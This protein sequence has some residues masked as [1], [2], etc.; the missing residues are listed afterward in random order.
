MHRSRGDS[1]PNIPETIVELTQVLE[2]PEWV[3]LTT[4]LDNEDRVYCCSVTAD[5]GSHNVIFASARG[6]ELLRQ[7][8]IIF[9]DGTFSITPA[10]GRCYQVC[11]NLSLNEPHKYWSSNFECIRICSI[12]GFYCSNY[13]RTHSKCKYCKKWL[14]VLYNYNDYFLIFFRL[15]HWFGV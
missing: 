13:H 1:F 6:L 5:D 7:V 8:T 2:D 4:S 11:S 10:I 12:A 3:S 14:K 15:Y 9:V